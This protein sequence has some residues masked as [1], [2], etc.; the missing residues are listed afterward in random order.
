MASLDFHW[1][2]SAVE[3][4]DNVWLVVSNIFYFHLYLEKKWSNLTHIFQLYT[5]RTTDICTRPDRTPKKT[6]C[7]GLNLSCFSPGCFFG[8][9]KWWWII[10][11]GRT[12]WVL[13]ELQVSGGQDESVGGAKKI[14][15]FQGVMMMLVF[16]DRRWFEVTYSHEYLILDDF[17]FGMDGGNIEPWRHGSRSFL[18]LRIQML[19]CPEFWISEHFYKFPTNPPLRFRNI[20]LTV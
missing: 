7:S 18:Y 12:H 6:I 16:Q 13:P 17:F 20:R 8:E 15:R 11:V 5:Y 1:Q 3:F 19:F 14:T 4:T 2:F 9:T 10:P